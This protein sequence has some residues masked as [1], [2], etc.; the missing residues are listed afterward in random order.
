MQLYTTTS[1][2]WNFSPNDKTQNNAV[3]LDV[4]INEYTFGRTTPDN[5]FVVSTGLIT[6][7]GGVEMVGGSVK[8]PPVKKEAVKKSPVKKEPVKKPPVKKPPVK[9]APV[10]KPPVKKEPV[11]KKTVKK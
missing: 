10:K 1:P 7:S 3:N 2:G 8:K 6:N 5:K 11:K 9:K 4:G